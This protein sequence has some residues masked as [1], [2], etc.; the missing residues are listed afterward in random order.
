MEQIWLAASFA[1]ARRQAFMVAGLPD[2]SLPVD[3][4]ECCGLGAVGC[5]YLNSWLR[6]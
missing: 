3:T 5:Y 1:I 4:L 2:I 6:P